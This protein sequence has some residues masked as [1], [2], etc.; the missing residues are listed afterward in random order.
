MSPLVATELLYAT[1]ESPLGELLLVGDGYALLGLHMQRG[2]KA[3]PVDPGWQR[4]EEQFSNVRVQLEE[5]FAGRRSVFDLPLDLRG[6][7]FQRRVWRA[8]L[9][10]PY[11]ETLTYGELA[12]RIGQPSAARAV[13]HA[14]GSNPLAVIVPCHRLVGANGTLVDYGGGLERKQHLLSLEARAMRTFAPP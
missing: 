11:G 4:S 13:G 12:S 5:Y 1:V 3:V 2:R 8:L 14:N 9:G 10:V 6:T 7:A